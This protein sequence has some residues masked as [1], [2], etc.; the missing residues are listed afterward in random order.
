MAALLPSYLN[1][2]LVSL[3]HK[4]P[5]FTSPCSLSP[6]LH[7]SSRR[8]PRISRFPPPASGKARRIRVDRS[9]GG[10]DEEPSSRREGF[11]DEWGEK[12]EPE[13]E[14]PAEADPSK[15]DDEWG[16]EVVSGGS[17][18][19]TVITDEWGEKSELEPEKPATPDPSLDDD[20]CGN[21]IP[22]PDDKLG[23]LK[24]CL[25]DTFY[26]TELGLSASAEVR[27]EIVELVTQL[28]AQNPTPA[29]NEAPELLDGN[30]ILL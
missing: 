6:S 27:A 26:G 20:E 3:T 18:A 16:K 10:D 15:D 17:K 12:A 21:G 25:V 14:S 1:P 29:P 23:E 30:W 13:V 24:R 19:S 7:Q 28:E 2:S 5:L 4:K 9:P 22:T 8:S 11:A